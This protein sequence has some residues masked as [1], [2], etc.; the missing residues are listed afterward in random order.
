MEWNA[1]LYDGRHGFVSQY[2]ESL[3]EYIPA[4]K[5]LSVLDLGCGTGILTKE[6]SLRV[7]KVLGADA[8]ADM[9]RRARELYPGVKFEVLD[10]LAME[11]KDKWDVVFSNAVFHWIP[12]HDR[13]LANVFRAL[14]KGGRLVCEFGAEGNI[15][16]IEEVFSRALSAKGG[17][18]ESPFY[19]P[20]PADYAELLRR[21]GFAIEELYDYDRPTPLE[22]GEKG[23]ENW[24]RQFF[25]GHLEGVSPDECA[26][27]FRQVEQELK[28][29]LWDGTRWV[30]DYRRMRVVAV[31]L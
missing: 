3:L 28:P 13:L 20:S 16:R 9:V 30:A 21:A 15:T 4:D 8:S 7:G 6:L 22:D 31:K 10:A 12:R 29:S 26:R 2:G 19:F 14:K 23:L 25:A 18:Y 27:L 11:W 24:M 17:V 5:G 1:D